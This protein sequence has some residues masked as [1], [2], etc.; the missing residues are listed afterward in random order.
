M[1]RLTDK[2]QR[3]R[4]GKLHSESKSSA[5]DSKGFAAG[6]FFGVALLFAVS[7]QYA[8]MDIFIRFM[9]GALVILFVAVSV[10]IV[11]EKRN[12]TKTGLVAIG[13]FCVLFIYNL[14]TT[15][16]VGF[17]F[18]WL[19]AVLFATKKLLEFDAYLRAKK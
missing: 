5:F 9:L 12:A 8:P 15:G 2:N 7:S 19:V 16:R 1:G 11:L 13:L 17:G 4:L 18:L 14:V 10:M 3:R 6:I